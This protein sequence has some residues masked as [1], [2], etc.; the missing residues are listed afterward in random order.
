MNSLFK[1]VALCA[2][3]SIAPK[4]CEAINRKLDQIGR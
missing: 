4:A 3:V 2:L 1:L